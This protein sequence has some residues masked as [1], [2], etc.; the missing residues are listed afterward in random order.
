MVDLSNAALAFAD[1]SQIASSRLWAVDYQ[2]RSPFEGWV[3]RLTFEAPG[4]AGDGRFF[5]LACDA[6]GCIRSLQPRR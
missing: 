2:P 6:N 4:G 1:L 3:L 5:F